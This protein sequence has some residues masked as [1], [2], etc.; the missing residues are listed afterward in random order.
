M[1]GSR[2]DACTMVAAPISTTLGSA[3]NQLR[4]LFY[5]LEEFV[6]AGHVDLKTSGGTTMFQA[7]S[8]RPPQ[9]TSKGRTVRNISAVQ[10]LFNIFNKAQGSE[11][12]NLVLETMQNIYD[13]VGFSPCPLPPN[14]RGYQNG[15][16]L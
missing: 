13:K 9:P 5:C 1:I 2:S 7:S 6:S 8:F 4:Q 11:L 15:V 12:C 14:V 16:V 10:S 3:R